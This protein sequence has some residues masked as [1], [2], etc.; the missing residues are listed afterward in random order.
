MHLWNDYEGTTIAGQWVLGR[1]LRTEG[2]SALFATD[3][4]DGGGSAVLRLTEALNDQAVLGARYRAI[5][6]AGDEFLVT[7]ESYG[8]AEF[9][10][11]PLSYAVL[12]PTQETLAEILSGRR[13]GTDETQE[14]A[15]NVAGGLL[16][17]HAQGLVH[18]LV[19][20]ESVVAAGLCAACAAWRRGDARERGD[21]ADG[22]LWAGRDHLLLA[23]AEPVARCCGCAGAAG[24]VRDDCAES[25][26]RGVGRWGDCRGA[27]AARGGCVAGA[28]V[29]CGGC[30]AVRAR[31]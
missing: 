6:A 12:E 25:G 10:G 4:T 7:V 21:A 8:D 5:Q 11:T 24:A 1:L 16:A 28:A 2:R 18:G 20:P 29:A 15:T 3:R 13:L 31:G 23:D 22:C 30:C 19:E 27:E 9:D 14:V 17:L 26:A